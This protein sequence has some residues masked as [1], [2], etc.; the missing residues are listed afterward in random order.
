MN[1]KLSRRDFLKLSGITSAGLALSA[2]GVKA[3]A[4]PIPTLTASPSVT[5]LPVTPTSTQEDLAENPVL[6]KAADELSGAL[7]KKNILMTPDELLKSLEVTKIEVTNQD[8]SFVNIDTATVDL[9]DENGSILRLPIA[10]KLSNTENSSWEEVTFRAIGN[11]KSQWVGSWSVGSDP[12]LYGYGMQ[13]T[14]VYWDVAA[15]KFNL[16]KASIDFN[17]STLDTV[18]PKGETADFATQNIYQRGAGVFAGE[19]VNQNIAGR[20]K[21]IPLDVNA[22]DVDAFIDKRIDFILSHAQKGKLFY[23]DLTSELINM[24]GQWE[25]TPVHDKYGDRIL[26]ELYERVYKKVQALGLKL[27][28]DVIVGYEDYDLE[29]PGKKQDLIYDLLKDT[30]TTLAQELSEQYGIDFAS[31]PFYISME[32]GIDGSTNRIYPYLPAATDVLEKLDVIKQ[33]VK[34]FQEIGPILIGE[35]A[36][37]GETSP[38]ISEAFENQKRQVIQQVASLS[39]D[40]SLVKGII[41]YDTFAEAVDDKGNPG[42]D[43]FHANPGIIDPTDLRNYPFTI[44]AYKVF[45]RMLFG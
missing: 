12:R 23:F 36:V 21:E 10:L 45:N 14:T 16:V 27:G 19:I 2:C 37:Y 39:S 44:D 26:V 29:M 18:D 13:D 20:P 30:Q 24:N 4:L 38:T 31:L 43:E 28:E 6:L 8:G 22:E 40:P 9:P 35:V 5:P 33:S 25:S 42:N 11:A 15:G 3:T 17:Q 32:F 1:K 34:R 7:K 41:F